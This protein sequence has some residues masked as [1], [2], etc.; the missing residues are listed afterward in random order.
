MTGSAGRGHPGIASSPGGRYNL[1]MA[2]GETIIGAGDGLARSADVAGENLAKLAALFPGVVTE[3]AS[4]PAVD[5]EALK[6]LVGEKPVEEGTAGGS[7]RFGL[8]WHGKADARRLA[9]TPSAGTLR[10]AVEESVDWDTTQNLMIEGDNLEVLKLLQKGYRGRVK[11]IYIDPPY[12]TGKDFVYPDDFR[13]SLKNYREL[14]AEPPKTNKDT[15][16]RFHTDWLNMMY[17]RLMLAREL[18]TEDGSMFVS[19]GDREVGNLRLILDEVFGDDNFVANVVWQKKYAVS[20]DDPGI[21]E[22]HDHILVVSKSGAFER[23]LLPRTDKQLSRY[24]NLDDDPRGDWSSDNYVSNKSKDERP[25]LWYPVKHP[26]TGEDVWPSEDAV[27]RYSRSKHEELQADGRLYWGPDDSYEKPRIKRFVSEL[28]GGVVPGTWWTFD[29]VGHNDEGQK[30][31]G[32]LIGKKV[33]STPKPVRMLQRIVH[34][35]SNDGDLVMDFFAG[36]G[37][38]AHAVEAQNAVDGLKRRFVMVQMPEKCDEKSTSKKEGFDTIA[39]ITRERLRRAGQKVQ[40]DHPDWHGDTG[41][42]TFKLDTS[43]VTAWAAPR[44]RDADA[45][46]IASLLEQAADPIA[47]DRSEQDLFF[48]V[49]LKHGLPGALSLPITADRVPCNG[50]TLTVRGVGGAYRGAV[51]ACLDPAIEPGHVEPLA[52]A[53]EAASAGWEGELLIVLR[54]SAFADDSTK[55]NLI[56]AVTQGFRRTDEDAG[57]PGA[58]TPRVRTL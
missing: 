27:W 31:T 38:F 45:E 54:D 24:K 43:N 20:S 3:G 49:L 9:L 57:L 55:L 37:A 39:D 36:S 44:A 14:I 19:I 56:E 52:A 7:P 2:D 23:N 29:E 26:R 51:L 32:K 30:E 46:H 34:L 41:F 42:R 50:K 53:L 10:P 40:T 6:D 58:R 47:P 15:T 18:L 33:F 22:M 13:E 8:H 28:P 25:T 35:C 12:N 5:V 17:P 16:G 21:A 1:R 4:G 48:E 11:L